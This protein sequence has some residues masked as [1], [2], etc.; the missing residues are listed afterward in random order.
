MTNDLQRIGPRLA[1]HLLR[2]GDAGTL[3]RAVQSAERLHRRAHGLTDAGFIGDVGA[4]EA[5]PVAEFLRQAL[6]GRRVEIGD[7]HIGSI[8]HQH[9]HTGRPETG[10]AAADEK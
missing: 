6:T 4:D 5:D 3:N 10:A 7:D 8:L 9:A 2:D 1:Q